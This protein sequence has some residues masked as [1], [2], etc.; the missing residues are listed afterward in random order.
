MGIL[1]FWIP[2]LIFGLLAGMNSLWWIIGYI[3]W[4]F[5]FGDS[6]AE[7]INGGRLGSPGIFIFFVDII[8]FIAA[9]LLSALLLPSF[10][11]LSFMR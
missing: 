4:L 2:A 5:K 1:L 10:S 11:F 6:Y 7:W 9:G 8:V 3:V